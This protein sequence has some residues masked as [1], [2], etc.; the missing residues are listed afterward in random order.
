M[1]AAAQLLRQPRTLVTRSIDVAAISVVIIVGAVANAN[2][3]V[4]LRSLPYTIPVR[5]A[6]APR[7]VTAAAAWRMRAIA[8]TVVLARQRPTLHAAV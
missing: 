6:N 2:A 5:A 4:N 8:V 7:G 1:H 3:L